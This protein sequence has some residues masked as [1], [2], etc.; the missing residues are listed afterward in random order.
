VWDRDS[1]LRS[2]KETV[3]VNVLAEQFLRVGDKIK[4]ATLLLDQVI[5]YQMINNQMNDQC[6]NVQI[7]RIREFENYF[8]HLSGLII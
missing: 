2:Q 5:N 6:S 4:S 3:C 1:S 7:L 8:D